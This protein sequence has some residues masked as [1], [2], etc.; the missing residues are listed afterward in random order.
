MLPHAR[1]AGQ[2]LNMVAALEDRRHEIAV[3]C[4]KWG[5]CAPTS[6]AA[7]SARA[8]GLEG[9]FVKLSRWFEIDTPVGKYNPDW[10]I[11]KQNGGPLYLVRETKGT[12]DF[13][14]LRTSEA[15][16]VRCSQKHFEALGV[17]FAVAVT[18]DEVEAARSNCAPG[19]LAERS[20]R[21]DVYLHGGSLRAAG[22]P[23]PDDHIHL[24]RE[25]P[26]PRLSR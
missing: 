4:R 5:C 14:K 16:N 11:L 25:V 15:D 9:V 7:R 12:R 21:P 20:C 3:L 2:T 10:A 17:P 26:R 8:V 18:A 23:R 13:L 24:H 6:S 1:D 22:I 19:P